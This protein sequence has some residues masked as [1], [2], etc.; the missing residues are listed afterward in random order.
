LNADSL[1]VKEYIARAGSCA[2]SV[3]SPGV[4]LLSFVSGACGATGFSTGLAKFQPRAVLPY[5]RHGFSEAVTIVEGRARI[6]AEGRSYL[7]TP[8][9]AVHFPAGTAHQVENADEQ[10]QL[11]AHWAFATDSPSREIVSQHFASIGRGAGQPAPGDPEHIIRYSQGS[12]Y[13]LAPNAY[14]LDLFARRY[15][16]TGICGGHGRFLPGASLPCHT[17]DYDESITIVKGRAV[18]LVQGRRYELSGCD[19]A[20]I[21]RGLPHRFLNLSD[22]EMEMVWVYAGSEPDRQIIDAG[23]CSGDLAWPSTQTA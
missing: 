22:E 19:C 17:H 7:L 13:E 9:D 6:M 18:C 10:Q 8:R 3:A 11:V 5:H 12:I 20:F 16:S 14:F 23:F 15:G 21:P 2:P 4:E 1:A